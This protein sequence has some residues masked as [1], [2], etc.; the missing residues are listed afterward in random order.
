MNGDLWVII[1]LLGLL[2]ATAITI[3]R[4][5]SLFAAV[6]LTGI[7]SFLGAGWM[8]FLDA[9]DVAFTEAAVGAGI[10]TVVMLSTLGLTTRNA[11]EPVGSQLKPLV[12]VIFT[13]AFLIYATLDMPHFGDPNAPVHRHPSPSYVERTKEDIH[14]P[15]VVTAVLASYRGYDTLGETVV[16]FTA[17]LGVLLLLRRLPRRKEDERRREQ[18]DPVVDL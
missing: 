11:K 16:V 17:G 18:D 10:S 14:V 12:I 8:L 4:M 1:P 5:R 7:F 2:S 3:V 13:G 15:N 6:M 9:P